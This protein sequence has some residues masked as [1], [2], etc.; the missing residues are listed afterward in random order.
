[1]GSGSLLFVSSVFAT[2][3]QEF[4][5]FCMQLLLRAAGLWVGVRAGSFLLAVQGFA[6]GSGLMA[7]VLGGWYVAQVLRYEHSLSS[8][9]ASTA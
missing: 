1:M 8:T 2:Q 7:V 3:K 4:I 5:L 6:V 9:D